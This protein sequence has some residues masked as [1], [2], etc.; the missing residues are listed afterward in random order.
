[1]HCQSLSCRSHLKFLWEIW[2]SYRPEAQFSVRSENKWLSTSCII[3][4]HW[5]WC[6]TRMHIQT[7]M[8]CNYLLRTCGLSNLHGTFRTGCMV[9][10]PWY[11]QLHRNQPWWSMMI[12]LAIY[13]RFRKAFAS[14][15]RYSARTFTRNWLLRN[16]ANLHTSISKNMSAAMLPC[17]CSQFK[18]L[19]LC[20]ACY[21][22][23]T[24]DWIYRPQ[25]QSSRPLLGPKTGLFYIRRPEWRQWNCNTFSRHWHLAPTVRIP[26]TKTVGHLWWQKA[27]QL[28][29]IRRILKLAGQKI[30]ESDLHFAPVHL[31]LCR[32][33][34]LPVESRIQ[35]YTSCKLGDA[36]AMIFMRH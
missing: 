17:K 12:V 32:T 35:L 1:M 30:A 16:V 19:K 6:F 31:V 14:H 29:K 15:R 20:S 34:K 22:L 9:I 18:T 26:T 27:F 5:V 4:C 25:S 36:H 10:M 33:L 21:R 13:S 7:N 24:P 8:D 28:D 23:L 3:T 11:R 2:R